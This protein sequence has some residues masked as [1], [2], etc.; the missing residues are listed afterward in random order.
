[1]LYEVITV[2]FQLDLA[3]FFVDENQ[4]RFMRAGFGIVHVFPTGDNH[5]I[6]F[7]H[8]AGRRT[9]DADNAAAGL[10]GNGIGRKPGTEIDVPDID[11]LVVRNNFV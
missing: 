6:A 2:F 1:M 4:L 10:S 7:G 8:F 9:V 11:E 5:Q 3:I